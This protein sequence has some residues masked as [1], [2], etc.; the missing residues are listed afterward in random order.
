MIRKI[1]A[2]V[3]LL[4]LTA[5][6]QCFNNTTV[7]QY[8]YFVAVD[9]TDFTTRETGLSSF[10]VYFSKDGGT[11]TAM[12]TPTINETDAT[13]QPGVYELL[14][15]EGTTV[16]AG[17]DMEKVVYHVTAF[18]LLGAL[19]SRHIVQDRF[20]TGIELDYVRHE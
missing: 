9:S 6:A 14:L 2:L 4:P 12:T 16:A 1:L 13:F 8:T 3:M 17:N 18:I 10:T 20:F 15:D 5:G 19:P 7:D 11:S